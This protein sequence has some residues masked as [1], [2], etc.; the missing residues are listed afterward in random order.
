MSV[1]EIATMTFAPGVTAADFAPIDAQVERDHVSQQPGFLSRETGATET[2]WV[3]IVRW[4][5]A[6]AA[7]AS[8]DSFTS[9]PA[10]SDFMAALDADSITMTRYQA[11]K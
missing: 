11:T 5:S 9:A 2:G 3:A 4:E 7:Q 1:I 8:M 6:D 10:A